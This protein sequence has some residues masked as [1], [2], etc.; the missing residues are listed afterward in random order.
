MP[1][2][3]L[4]RKMIMKK[5]FYLGVCFFLT[6]YFF[7]LQAQGL[8]GF[9]LQNGLT[10]YVW[11]D[12]TKPDV[13][14]MVGVKVGSVD[15]PEDLTGLAH[16]LEHMMFK[17]T[18]KISALDWEKEQP[19]YEQI[20]AKYDEKANTQD[21]EKK[22][23]LDLEIN[24]LTVEAAQYTAPNEFAGLTENMG[25]KSLNAATSYDMT[26]YFSSFPPSQLYRWLELN[27]E[28]FI[29]PVFRAFQPELETVYEEFNRS[30]DSH[31][32]LQQEYLLEHIF[33]GHPYSRSVLGLQDH[34]KNPRLSGLVKFYNDWYVPENM[35]LILVG[36][37][38]MREVT[39][40][41]NNL[42]G[43]LPAKPSP[44]RVNYPEADF[45]GRVEYSAKIADYPTLTL[46]YKGVP[47]GSEDELALEVCTNLLS[48]RNRTGLLDKLS[49]DGNIMGASA[50]LLDFKDQGRIVIY[51]IPSYDVN[52]RRFESLKSL[53]KILL[54]EIEK[55]QKGEIEDWRFN[56]VKTAMMRDY[57]LAFESSESKAQMILQTFVNNE[58]ISNVLT[59][60]DRLAAISLDKVKEI[61][62]K[63]FTDN[64]IAFNFQQGK[65]Q[66]AE[67]LAKPQYEPINP[68]R[69]A[70]SEYAKN[71]SKLPV[72]Q[73]EPSYA[74]F[75]EVQIKPINKRSK[76][77][78]T[79]NKENNVF[80]LTLKYG[81][82]TREM[83]KL[84]Y[85][86]ALME[87]AG[88]M[89]SFDPQQLKQEFSALGAVC[90]FS[91]SEN[92]LTITMSGYEENLAAA[93]QL[94]SRQILM[95]QLDEQQ[96]NQ[97]KGS[98]YQ[99]RAIE[100]DNPSS[101]ESAMYEYMLYQDKSS[102]INRMPLN[103]ILEL[104]ISNL[105]GEFNRATDYEA[106]VHY[107]GSL[108]FESAY[109][110]LSKNLPLK[111]EEKETAS[112]QVKDRVPYSENTIYFISDKDAAQSRIYFYIEGNPYKAEDDVY[113]STFN[114]YFGNG[115]GGLVMQEVREYRS[116]AYTAEGT[117]VTPFL[118][119][120]NAYFMGY[121]GT[122][123]DKTVDAMDIFMGLI[124]NMPQYADRIGNI[125]DY[126]REGL[127]TAKPGFR[128]ASQVYEAWKRLGY[129][130][131]P[132]KSELP[133]IN[134][135]TFEDVLKFYEQ[136]VKG[137]PVVIGII[138]NPKQV[139]F[140]A[141]EKYG[142]VVRLN[143]SKLFS[144]D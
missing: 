10:V 9:K 33:P 27:S 7:S 41:V 45:K 30:Q 4:N 34:L 17:G 52:Q 21:P 144:A 81:V 140:T 5:F 65:P 111:A 51:G 74:D 54:A 18:Q 126:L 66:K 133:K 56:S 141:L 106:E 114:K 132:A 92:Y 88:I 61:A 62:K 136:N 28:R 1:L 49:L 127:Q 26:M 13:F 59:Y 102:Y 129:T 108:P 14:G 82:G 37:V 103:E 116:M 80:T 15:D 122:Q 16:Y 121:I 53:E 70:V 95:P 8:K 35:V 63:Y 2:K 100:T 110:I 84:D 40:L 119:D 109:D 48:N 96:L 112:P 113:Y 107:V 73:V 58:D 31:G 6:A 99:M 60:K 138:G 91:V 131:D 78:Y 128:E 87:N 142:K 94:L 32:R 97:L 101:L 12:E 20:I 134:G 77:F 11:E 123:G 47:S 50:S 29:N 22:K 44:E 19:L 69:N 117:Y 67:K 55:M 124:N 139:D 72:K 125:K 90:N 46:A 23:S 120:K 130:E 86:T 85:A 83:P 36:N 57:D 24:K 98:A 143:K 104:S 68:P 3:W 79:P 71:F 89:G 105:T 39:G 64:Y 93:C 76:L 118:K 137:R 43:R 42:F 135:L 38:K 115:F 25:G 75:N